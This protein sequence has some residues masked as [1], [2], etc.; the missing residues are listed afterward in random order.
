MAISQPLGM[1]YEKCTASME[2]TLD[3]FSHT[4]TTSDKG[5]R[6]TTWFSFL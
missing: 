4:I 1:M 6:G 2:L 3:V 5:V